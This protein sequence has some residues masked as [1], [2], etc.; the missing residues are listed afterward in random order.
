[1]EFKLELTLCLRHSTNL[2]TTLLNLPASHT[3][4]PIRRYQMIGCGTPI[5]RRYA[6]VSRLSYAMII[7]SG[8]CVGAGGARAD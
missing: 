4:I 8:R 6:V 7:W 2:S 3:S 5:Q 1:M